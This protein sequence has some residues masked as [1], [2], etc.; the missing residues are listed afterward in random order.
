MSVSMEKIK[1]LR[2]E[3]SAKLIDCKKALEEA[4]GNIDEARKILR[5]KGAKIAQKKSGEKTGQGTIA[6]YVH[7]NGNVGVLVEVHCQSDFVART[8]EFQTFAKDIAMHIAAFNPRWI[9]PEEVPSPVIEEE[10]DILRAQA[11]QEGKPDKIIER[12][13]EGRIK[14]FYSEKCLLSQ[15]FLKDEKKTVKEHLEELIAKVGENVRIHRFT[16]YELRQ[17]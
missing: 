4:G 15:P 14:K 9:S 16:R 13:V 8:D 6:S 3:T 5:K 10:K 12:I 7:H 2:E 17:E 1:R 11:R